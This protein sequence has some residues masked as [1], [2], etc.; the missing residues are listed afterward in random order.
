M[1]KEALEDNK[2]ELHKV[3]GRIKMLLRKMVEIGSD[4]VKGVRGRQRDLKA[5]LDEQ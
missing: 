3:N 4:T 1:L 2:A 5:F